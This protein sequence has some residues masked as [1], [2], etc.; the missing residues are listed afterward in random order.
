M[1]FLG[2]RPYQ[3]K[4]SNRDKAHI[5]PASMDHVGNITRNQK[6][7]VY[8]DDRLAL[9]KEL[10]PWQSGPEENR[11]KLTIPSNLTFALFMKKYLLDDNSVTSK[12]SSLASEDH[13]HCRMRSIG[14]IMKQLPIERTE[15]FNDYFINVFQLTG[16]LSPDDDTSFPLSI[17]NSVKVDEHGVINLFSKLNAI[18]AMDPDTLGN[19][20]YFKCKDE[21]SKSI[22]FISNFSE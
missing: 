1:V 12:S 8:G 17:V 10:C 7:E 3:G 11:R 21:L 6:T 14:K 16:S 2:L 18:S 5:V 9:P 22:C 19:S 4:H 15:M 13:G 20:F